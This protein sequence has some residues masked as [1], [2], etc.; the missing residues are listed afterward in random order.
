MENFK[1]KD[2]SK[3]ILLSYRPNWKR[4]HFD[5][6]TDWLSEKLEKLCSWKDYCNC[7]LLIRLPKYLKDLNCTNLFSSFWKDGYL[8]I[9]FLVIVYAQIIVFIFMFCNFHRKK[10]AHMDVN[11]PLS[12]TY[13]NQTIKTKTTF[14]F[15]IK[16]FRDTD[17]IFSYIATLSHTGNI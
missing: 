11:G 9:W 14:C 12:H 6:Q 5:W 8:K 15:S 16:W 4:L 2:V 13:I 1:R 17:E 7:L 3:A 10:R